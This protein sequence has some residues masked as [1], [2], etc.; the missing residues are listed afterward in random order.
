MKNILITGGAGFIGSNLTRYFASKKNKVTIFDNL[1]RYG[2]KDNI[3]WIKSLHKD[4]K[5]LIGD[6]RDADKIKQALKGQD[7]VFHL[8][9]QVAVT[10]SIKNPRLDFEA[11]ALGT[12]NVLE[13]IRINGEKPI[14]IYA[15]T[16]KVYG[17][18]EQIKIIKKGNRYAYKNFPLGIP[19]TMNLDFHSPYGCSKGVGDQYVRDYERIYDIPTVVFRQSCIYGPRQFGV[20]DQ[21]WLAW[22]MLAITFGKPVT[23]FGDGN[24]VRDILYIDDLVKAYEKAIKKINIARG[25]IYNVGGGASYSISIWSQLKPI[26]EKLFK[27]KIYPRF[28]PWRPGDQKIYISDISKIEKELDWKPKINVEEGIERLYIWITNNKSLFKNFS[29]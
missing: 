23:I 6:V 17:A 8:A 15:S 13:G 21:G 26:L 5:V 19:E 24:Q 29:F 16:N 2:A 20:E 4:V 10:T 7:I 12:I 18:I 1:S 27:K 3:I 28:G 11:N 14:I 25:K 9:G 22:F